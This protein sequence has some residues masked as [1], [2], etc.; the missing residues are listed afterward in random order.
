MVR[1]AVGSAL[2][3]SL[4]AGQSLADHVVGHDEVARG[5]IK[6]LDEKVF[7]LQLNAA[8]LQSQIDNITLTPGA[9]G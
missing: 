9:A 6:A 4:F 8:G 2:M 5:G 3:L 7:D 1:L